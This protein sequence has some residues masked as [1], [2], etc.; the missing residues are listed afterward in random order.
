MGHLMETVTMTADQWADIT[1][2]L[3]MYESEW[4]LKPTESNETRRQMWAHY[5]ALREQVEQQLNQ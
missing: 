5:K 1:H 2:A 4:L 3:L